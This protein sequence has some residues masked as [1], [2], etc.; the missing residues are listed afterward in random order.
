M[1][2]LLFQGLTERSIQYLLPF[3]N[4]VLCNAKQKQI[5]L[6]DIERRANLGDCRL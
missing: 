2:Q 6:R 3:R 5:R 4:I 1:N